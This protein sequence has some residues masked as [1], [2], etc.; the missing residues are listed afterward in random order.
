MI[1]RNMEEDLKD[2]PIGSTFEHCKFI[3]EVRE[4]DFCQDCSFYTPDVGCE[5]PIKGIGIPVCCSHLRKDRKSVVF[6]KV[7]EG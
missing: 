7:G 5:D 3:Y 1:L 6:V 4:S 2:L